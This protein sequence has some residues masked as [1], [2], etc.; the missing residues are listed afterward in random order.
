VPVDW[1]N[2]QRA[3][4]IN[5]R[6]EFFLFFV[7][8]GIFLLGALVYLFDR[9]AGD[10]YFIPEWWRFADGTPSLFGKLGGSLPSF[11]HT[12]CFIL[13]FSALLTPWSIRPRTVCIG[14]CS[15]E[16]LCE[17]AQTDALASR[18]EAILPNW[19]ADWPI[20]ANVSLYFLNGR[21]D[22]ADLAAI[23]LG[24]AAAWQ[25]LIFFNRR[26]SN[27]TGADDTCHPN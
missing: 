18:I 16:A 7:A 21:F 20:L 8:L 22:P 1:P 25:T 10:I 24:G 11:A 26:F 13:M 23:G 9:S 6:A 4:L 27:R 5:R 19:F 17:L 2:F 14:W 3:A 12:Y 15:V